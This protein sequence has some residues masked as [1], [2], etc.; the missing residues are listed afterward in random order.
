MNHMSKYISTRNLSESGLQQV[1]NDLRVEVTNSFD[2]PITRYCVVRGGYRAF[3]RASRELNLAARSYCQKNYR[4]VWQNGGTFFTPE[5]AKYS[6]A[7]E[8]IYNYTSD[9]E[10]YGKKKSW[11]T[12]YAEEQSLNEQLTLARKAREA[13]E[14]ELK[15][16]LKP[17]DKKR[18][19]RHEMNM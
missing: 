19:I 11:V 15:P 16:L 10:D 18:T 1:L 2:D 5:G 12:L 17:V 14:I 4:S 3:D 9:N 8:P 7:V 13:R 6:V